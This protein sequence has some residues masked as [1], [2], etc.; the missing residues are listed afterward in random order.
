MKLYIKMRN[1]FF[2]AS[3]ILLLGSLWA[4][5]KIKIDGLGYFLLGLFASTLIIAIQSAMSAQV[6]EGKLLVGKL[7]QLRD[8][9]FDF[10]IF[11]NLSIEHYSYDFENT[12]N[13]YMKDLKKIFELIDELGNISDL[14]GK[15]KAKLQKITGEFAELRLNLHFIFTKFDEQTDEMKIIYFMEFY[16]IIKEFNFDAKSAAIFSLGYDIDSEEFCRS[17]FSE[18]IT[19]KIRDY[20]YRESIDVYNEKLSQTHQVEYKALKKK[21]DSG[22]KKH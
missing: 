1:V 12:F 9:C 8:L 10:T 20:E 7:K 2:F 16:K 3:I 22:L 4:L 6:E 5:L 14:N 21:F 19:K 15:N 11:N 13:A 18:K 17:K